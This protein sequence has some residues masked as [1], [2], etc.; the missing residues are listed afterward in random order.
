[1]FYNNVLIYQQKN[2]TVNRLPQTGSNMTNGYEISYWSNSDRFYLLI[3]NHIVIRH[4]VQSY[5]SSFPVAKS[6]KK[7]SV[8]VYF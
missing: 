6:L 4:N 1:M 2:K 5:Q 8:G 3:D 7:Q